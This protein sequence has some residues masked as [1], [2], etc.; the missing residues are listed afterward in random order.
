MIV[1][2]SI[3]WH[4]SEQD[5]NATMLEIIIIFPSKQ[6]LYWDIEYAL[7]FTL[8]R[9]ALLASNTTQDDT[10]PK[11]QNFQQCII[12]LQYCCNFCCWSNIVR[13]ISCAENALRSSVKSVEWIY[14]PI[15]VH[16]NICVYASAITSRINGQCIA[17]WSCQVSLEIFHTNIAL[18]SF[19][20][21]CKK[22]NLV[23]NGLIYITYLILTSNF[24][25]NDL[26]FGDTCKHIC[27]MCI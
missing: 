3:F 15:R 18:H 22:I 1:I 27:D 2:N 21:W 5:E 13:C 20:A 6:Y 14:E 25:L 11:V 19:Y 8:D 23:H 16:D 12:L 10:T 7:L 9:N 26:N 17:T 4:R 24:L